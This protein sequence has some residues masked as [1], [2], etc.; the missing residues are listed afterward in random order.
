MNVDSTCIF[1]FFALYFFQEGVVLRESILWWS[2]VR[3]LRGEGNKEGVL[4]GVEVASALR[5][6]Q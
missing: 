2:N 4:E 1:L 5:R 3:L 6:R